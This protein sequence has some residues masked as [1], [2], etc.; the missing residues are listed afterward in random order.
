MEFGEFAS[1]LYHQSTP[2]GEEPWK[3]VQL[4]FSP[5]YTKLVYDKIDICDTLRSIQS[6]I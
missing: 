2:M 6:A 4:L 1:Y 5:K 3:P